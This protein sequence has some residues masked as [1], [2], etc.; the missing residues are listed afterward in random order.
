M[1]KYQGGKLKKFVLSAELN[2]TSDRNYS[3][4]GRSAQGWLRMISRGGRSLTGPLRRAGRRVPAPAGQRT[5]ERGPLP[6]APDW[7][8]VPGNVTPHV[9]IPI[10]LGDAMAM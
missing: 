5:E 4:T 10:S 7:A 2:M 6:T 8:P 9:V 3:G 1:T